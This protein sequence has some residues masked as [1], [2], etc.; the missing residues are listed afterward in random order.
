MSVSKAL[1]D[2]RTFIDRLRIRGEL[3]EIN[4]EIDPRLELAEIHRRVIE[5]NGPALLFKNVRGSRFPVV[6]NL[7]GT[8]E[9]ADLAFGTEGKDLIA[10]A[11]RLTH[12]LVPPSF[13]K[14]WNNQ[15]LLR[16]F[17]SAGMKR[18]SFDQSAWSKQ[19]PADL[20][21]LPVTT[22][23]PEDGGPFFTLPLVYTEHPETKVHN[24]GI[25][26]MQRYDKGSTGMHFQI[27]KGGGFHLSRAKELGRSLPVNVFIGGP[28]V[29]TLAA[30]APLPENVPE[31]LLAALLLGKKLPLMSAP[32]SDHP[33]LSGAEFVLC[34]S[35]D[36]MESRPEGPFGDH[37]GYYSLTH[38]FPVFRCEK[39][40]HRPDAI[41]PATV[42]GKPRQ[43]DFYIGDYLQELLSPL[44]PL[45]MPAVKQLWS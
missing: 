10:G 34:G 1:P 27:G 24:L 11:V 13:S 3:R 22:S 6:T 29:A 9:R 18:R 2:L 40:Y 35:V 25:Y 19:Q 7:Y 12:E 31:L 44:F 8:A 15:K 30:V 43:E 21:S 42:V 17:A 45:V 36:P 20:E 26:R 39:I 37:Y 38:D 16:R 32:G 14:I 41:F 4:A 23:W 28:P 33:L 5:K